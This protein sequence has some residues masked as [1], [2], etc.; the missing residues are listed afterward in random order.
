[1]QLTLTLRMT[2]AQVVETPVTVNNNSPIQDHVH[3]DDQTQ[4]FEMTPGFKPFTVSNFIS[5][6]TS[7]WNVEK[8]FWSW[9]LQYCMKVYEAKK[10]FVVL[11]SPSA[12]KREDR[13]FH[14]VVIQTDSKEMY[15]IAWSTRLQICCYV[16][17]QNLSFFAV[18]V[19]IVGKCSVDLSQSVS[20]SLFSMP[21]KGDDS[22]NTVDV[23]EHKYSLGPA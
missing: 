7:L 20:L 15:K 19:D 21:S 13:H 2:T 9:I 12:T 14:V 22:T 6:I 1:M 18:L 8:C 16:V 11:C 4:P 5:L 17:N 23:L 3:P 10:K